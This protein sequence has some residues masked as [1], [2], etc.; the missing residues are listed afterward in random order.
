MHIPTYSGLCPYQIR[1][2]TR[3]D[4]NKLLI[5][6]VIALLFKEFVINLFKVQDLLISTANIVAHHKTS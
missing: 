1:A 5:H 3:D 2:F 6:I 4:I